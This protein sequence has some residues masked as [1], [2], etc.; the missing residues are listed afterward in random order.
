MINRY[1]SVV[2]QLLDQLPEPEKGASEAEAL[3]EFVKG[4]GRR[5]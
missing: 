4:K 1:S 2:K 5:Q 3:L